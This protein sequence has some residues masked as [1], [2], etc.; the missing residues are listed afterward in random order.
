MQYLKK[1]YDQLVIT[2]NRML[3]LFVNS[4]PFSL[5]QQGQKQTI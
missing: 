3:T 5:S 1:K 4:M 2:I